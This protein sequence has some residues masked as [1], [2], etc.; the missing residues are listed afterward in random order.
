MGL[1]PGIQRRVFPTNGVAAP[2]LSRAAEE[3]FINLQGQTLGWGTSGEK[4]VWTRSPAGK[5]GALLIIEYKRQVI[6][7][8][9]VFLMCR[10]T[11]SFTE[12]V[13]HSH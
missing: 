7:T 9:S 12:G 13:C 5:S 6:P 4:S 1:L 10:H 3:R 2:A 11:P 8:V